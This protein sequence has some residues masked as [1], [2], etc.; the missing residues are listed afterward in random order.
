[1]RLS[2]KPIF[3]LGENKL[4]K[5]LHK[6]QRTDDQIDSLQLQQ[7]RHLT[8]GEVNRTLF[9]FHSLT[10][11]ETFFISRLHPDATHHFRKCALL[12]A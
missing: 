8:P 2:H 11:I 10:S 5:D 4:F 7:H 12:Q 6:Y 9:E 3:S 1:M